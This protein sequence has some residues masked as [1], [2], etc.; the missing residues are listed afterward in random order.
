MLCPL[1]YSNFFLVLTCICL[2]E[3]KKVEIKY[4]GKL[5][6]CSTRH[7]YT[8]CPD[9]TANDYYCWYYTAAVLVMKA[10]MNEARER[11]SSSSFFV[12]HCYPA[13]PVTQTI[14]KIFYEPF[15]VAAC[16][17][18]LQSANNVK[19]VFGWY[20]LKNICTLLCRPDEIT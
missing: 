20:P 17:R 2:P 19:K 18:I 8:T 9:I 15:C 11:K 5:D 7:D 12:C 4:I 3:Y 10:I 13:L 14:Q 1:F 16:F 6:Y